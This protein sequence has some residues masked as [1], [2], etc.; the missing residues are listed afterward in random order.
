MRR[1]RSFALRT[2]AGGRSSPCNDR[3][4]A[5][6]RSKNSQSPQEKLAASSKPLTRPFQYERGS[7]TKVQSP[8]TIDSDVVAGWS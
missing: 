4:Q 8:R 5:L 1:G 7:D 3:E 6:P 2:V